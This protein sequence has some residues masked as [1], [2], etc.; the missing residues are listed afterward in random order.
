V[1]K[2]KGQILNDALAELLSD[3]TDIEGA[4]IVGTDGLVYAADVPIRDINEEM[5]GAISAAV[6]NMSRRG[7]N[8]LKRGEFTR[9]MIQGTLGNLIVAE[10]NEETLLV[11]L[12]RK[13]V[14][15]GMAFMEIRTMTEALGEL[16]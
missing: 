1:A 14:N 11:G 8:Q 13:S 12:T 7:V 2:T 15:L 4:A 5:V 6:L 3:S 16:L 10:I 9:T